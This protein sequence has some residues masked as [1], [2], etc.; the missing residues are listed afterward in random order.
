MF[1]Y[2]VKSTVI[3]LH[4]VALV[5]MNSVVVTPCDSNVP[6]VPRYKR[7]S[8]L[9]KSSLMY[10]SKISLVL[11]ALRAY[12]TSKLKVAPVKVVKSISGELNS[13]F[14]FIVAAKL[15]FLNAILFDPVRDTLSDFHALAPLFK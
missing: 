9:P 4:C 2:G 5:G 14:E 10:T 8:V 7:V 6:V 11:V 1:A 3:V 13:S 15:K 12:A